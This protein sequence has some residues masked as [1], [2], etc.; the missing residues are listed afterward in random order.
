MPAG[1]WLSIRITVLHLCI[2]VE[3]LFLKK[4]KEEKFVH[5]NVCKNKDFKY[6]DY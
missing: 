3:D 1:G 6:Q 5:T 2:L 4:Y